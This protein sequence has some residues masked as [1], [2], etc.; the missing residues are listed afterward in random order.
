VQL[1]GLTGGI[2]SGKSTVASLFNEFGF[3]VISADHIAREITAP[4]S[5]TLTKIIEH[6]G[7]DIIHPDGSLNRK[8][9]AY[10]VFSQPS[11]RQILNAIMHPQIASRSAEL[12]AQH[13]LQLTA[14]LIYELPLLFEN[15]LQDM[16]DLVIL[17][18]IPRELQLQRL[19]LRDQI[20]Q[21]EASD[22]ID[23]QMPLEQKRHLADYIIENTQSLEQLRRDVSEII[24]QIT[25]TKTHR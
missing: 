9:L 22:R 20:S 6:F 24:S 16:F 5:P 4:H 19:I 3:A 1:I 18:A 12:I 25:H 15:Q 23:S 14:Q 8:K 11:K 21:R 10:I 7:H 17:V 13:R 2:A